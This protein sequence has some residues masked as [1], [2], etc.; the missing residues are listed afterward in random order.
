MEVRGFKVIKGHDNYHHSFG[1]E[2]WN[3]PICP[4]CKTKMHLIFNFDLRDKRLESLSNGELDNIPLVSC[5]NCSSYWSPQIFSIDPNKKL[6]SIIEQ[7]DEE[8]W[9]SEEEDKLPYPLP[10]SDMKLIELEEGDIIKEDDYSDEF[11]PFGSEY[12]CRIMG[13][14]LFN[15]DYIHKKCKKCR[16]NMH[17]VATICSEDYDSEGLVHEKFSFNF[18]EAFLYF[19]LCKTCNVLE[20]EMQST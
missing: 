2:S 16:G 18:G 7:N 14:P 5:L 20:T 6:I 17:Y 1:G 8:N 15:T 19:Y 3:S 11:L 4:N 13:I 9:V 10:Y 12:V